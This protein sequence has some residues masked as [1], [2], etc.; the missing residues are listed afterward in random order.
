MKNKLKGKMVKTSRPKVDV[1]ELV[2]CECISCSWTGDLDETKVNDLGTMLC[3]NCKNE[4]M[5][6]ED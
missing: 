6:Y 5:I 2:N 1:Q 3:P 4:V